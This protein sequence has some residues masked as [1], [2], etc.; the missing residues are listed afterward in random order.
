[1]TVPRDEDNRFRLYV[2]RGGER[3]LLATGPTG[4]SIGCALV[5]LKAEGEWTDEDRVGILDTLGRDD[6]PGSWV[7]N[8]YA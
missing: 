6:V 1:M 4:E 8:P 7:V 3:R 5:T 2:V